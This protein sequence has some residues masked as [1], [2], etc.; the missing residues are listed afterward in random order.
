MFNSI[1]C[2]ASLK[3]DFKGKLRETETMNEIHSILLLCLGIIRG[4]EVSGV[5]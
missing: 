5:Y 4:I 1:P 2:F 3:Y